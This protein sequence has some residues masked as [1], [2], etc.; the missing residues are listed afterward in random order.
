MKRFRKRAGFAA[1]GLVREGVRAMAR[2]KMRTGLSALGISVGIAAIICV[3]AI[4]EGGSQQLARQWQNLGDNQVWIEAGAPRMAGV[5][6][7]TRTTKTL[8]V[9]D[10]EAIRAQ[11]RWVKLVS[12]NVD[13][14]VQTIY[15]NEN[16]GT[17]VHG[18]GPEY[19]AI[20]NFVFDLGAPF[21]NQDVAYANN[22]CVLGNTVR[23]QLFGPEDPIGKVIRIKNLPFTVVGALHAKGQSAMGFD[24]DDLVVVPY[25]TAMKKLLGMSWL[26]DIYAAATSPQAIPAAETEITAL[27]HDRHRIR[28]ME[29]DDFKIR[30]PE[31]VLEAQAAAQR[32]I[33]LCLVSL[34][35]IALLVGG[36]GIMNVMLAAVTERTREIGVRLAVGATERDVQVQFLGEAA[37][38]SLVGGVAGI[39]LGVAVCLGLGTALGWALPISGWAIVLGVIVAGG[40]GVGFGFYP[41][42]AAARL[43][44]IEALR[45]E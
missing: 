27:L 35:A 7:G 34:G 9:G 32:T 8:A 4:G 41:A 16:W 30:H 43:D 22:V 29:R 31:D 13:S 2:N 17:T 23:E 26:D 11:V 38:L 1:G 19:F 39:A 25:T 36:I 15:G 6:Q 3:A 33:T 42:R 20:K 28:G 12:P 45:F 21:T 5:Y 18:V 40:V 37:L 10:A 24:Q 44:P 14:S